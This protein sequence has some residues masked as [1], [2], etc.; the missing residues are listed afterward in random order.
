MWAPIW[1]PI[2]AFAARQAYGSSSVPPPAL[3]VCAEHRVYYGGLRGTDNLAPFW[4]SCTE[5]AV[6]QSSTVSETEGKSHGPQVSWPAKEGQSI[7]QS[8]RLLVDSLL[9]KKRSRLG[10]VI[11][12]GFFTLWG[13]ERQGFP[14]RVI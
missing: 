9:N 13:D 6:Q 10:S 2:P 7:S 14:N 1:T 11:R 12:A 8:I 5:Y 4:T 3:R